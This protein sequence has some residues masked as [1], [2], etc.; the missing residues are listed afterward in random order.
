MTC[1]PIRID[2]RERSTALCA[3]LVA[4]PDV[5]PTFARLPVADYVLSD[6]VGI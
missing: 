2:S 5:V 3:A 6:A 1:L 4:L